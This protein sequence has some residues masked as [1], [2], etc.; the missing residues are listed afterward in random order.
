MA[1]SASTPCAPVAIIMFNRPDLTREVAERVAAARPE[2][3]YLIADGPRPA[4]PEDKAL[5]EATRE[6][7]LS[8][9]WPCPVH[10][11]FAE[12]N[13][14]LRE[15]FS[16]GLD[17]VFDEVEQS[18]IVED[19]CLADPSFFPYATELLERYRD[20]ERVGVISGNNFL[21]GSRVTDDSYFFSADMRIWGWA[22]WGRVW[23]DFSREGL[24]HEWS[25]EEAQ[26]AVS[27]LSSPGRRRALLADAER[28]HK[29]NSWAL[30]FVL[31]AQRRGYVSVVPEKNLVSNIGFGAS[32][33]HT[34]FESF[35]AEVP[36]EALSFP[37]RHP[38]SIEENRCA[39][40]IE[41]RVARWQW[42]VFPLSHPIDFV[43]RV[44][45]YLRLISSKR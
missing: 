40:L 24:R 29:I 39:G 1:T 20:A 3:V 16:S 21:Q 35:T 18:I 33:T 34:K 11:V 44:F 19:D 2:A 41:A 4:H 27:R 22:T 23:R 38:Q 9:D 42:V 5:C 10:T 13:M 32:S 37:L 30:P 7:V 28:A 6:A 36:S 45:R 25:S 12:S 8:I 26:A 31:H 15:R 43:S 17:A 14:G